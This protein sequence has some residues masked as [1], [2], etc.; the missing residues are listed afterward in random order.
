MKKANFLQDATHYVRCAKY[1][2]QQRRTRF[3]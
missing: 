3:I 2:V 1:L